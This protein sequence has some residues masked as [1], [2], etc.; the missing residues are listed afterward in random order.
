MSTT[1][2]ND[3]L[4]ATVETLAAETGLDLSCGYIG[5]CDLHGNRF[6][7]RH[8]TVWVDNVRL[9]NRNKVSLGYFTT[10]KLAELIEAA[11]VEN[12]AKVIRRGYAEGAMPAQVL[13]WDLTVTTTWEESNAK[14]N[15]FLA[16]TPNPQKEN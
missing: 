1:E 10:D 3:R 12:L 8:W 15:A 16:T 6:D 13:H 14:L 11:T 2:L 4:R 9:P 5:N 7:E